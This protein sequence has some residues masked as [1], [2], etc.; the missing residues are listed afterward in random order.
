M[1]KQKIKKFKE[2]SSDDQKEEE[3]ESA[4][5]KDV[6][7]FKLDDF[8][9]TEYWENYYQENSQIFELYLSWKDLK[10]YIS[11]YVKKSK[12]C[13]YLGCGTSLLGYEINQKYEVPVKNV[14]FSQT[15]VQ[16][17][18]NN[19]KSETLVW[20]CCDVRKLTYK[21]NLYNCIIDKGTLDCLFC[22]EDAYVSVQNMMLEVQRVLKDNGFFLCLSNACEELRMPYFQGRDLK[23][24][25]K[26][27]TKIRKPILD[28]EFYY[29]Y[30][31]QK[32]VNE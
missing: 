12:R 1:E 21:K 18:N 3:E 14:D 11:H 10:P 16:I 30:I 6:A 23:W 26:E 2:D 13:L 8:D 25:V 17:M 9:Q 5:D 4:D 24:T 7:E 27:V 28:D 22:A 19:Y 15:C 20:E 29:L 31:I 32:I